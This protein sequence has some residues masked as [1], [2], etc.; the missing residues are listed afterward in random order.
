ML[1]QAMNNIEFIFE[2]I[3]SLTLSLNYNSDV[4]IIL[5]QSLCNQKF[6]LGDIRRIQQDI[7]MP[8]V[9]GRK[10]VESLYIYFENDYDRMVTVDGIR[11]LH[12]FYDNSW[13]ESYLKV[14]KDSWS[15]VRTFKQFEFERDYTQVVSLYKR[16]PSGN[17]IIVLNLNKKY[18]DD[19]LSQLKYDKDQNIY[20]INDDG[21]IVFKNEEN[22]GINEND[23]MSFYADNYNNGKINM[24]YINDGETYY[25]TMHHSDMHKWSYISLIP[26][27][28]L[29]KIPDL[30]RTVSL[31]IF[32][33][34]A[35]CTIL[36]SYIVRNSNNNLKQI[37]SMLKAVEEG[38]VIPD[39]KQK[40][41]DEYG[42]IATNII[43]TYDNLSI[44]K[45]NLVENKDT[46]KML[47]ISALQAQINPHF[48]I[49]TLQSIFWMSFQFTKSRNPVSIMIENI[50]QILDFVLHNKNLLVPIE[51]ELKYFKNYIVIQQI[52]YNN[53]FEVIW[54]I[55][56]DVLQ[57]LTIKLLL[58]PFVENSITHG[59]SGIEDRKLYLRIRILKKH[60]HIAITITDNGVGISKEKLRS[61]REQ[62]S[63]K[64]DE[65]SIGIYNC[66]RRLMLVFGD[67]Y[68][69]T[70]MSK[71]NWG[72]SC[73]LNLP[74]I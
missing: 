8:T 39:L 28:T 49:N 41:N 2:E 56:P 54:D 37:A 61:I 25:V 40:I 5:R 43:R 50:T 27:S 53:N 10:Y 52:R 1:L 69:I 24:E 16:I 18:F 15:E 59:F 57:Y 19:Q 6:D 32:L 65:G 29:Y 31:A 36:I 26:H 64:N 58:Q 45:Q 3:N 20:V 72:T 51:E 17:G 23:I 74:L 30:L 4:A 46:I 9:I 38:N 14:D 12:N 33:L 60:D 67:D 71:Q 66:N 68:H 73:R 7:I 42:F 35:S 48:L 13:Y 70:I 55:S 44:L 22:K 21:K 11:L 34:G 63:S 62:L 47:E